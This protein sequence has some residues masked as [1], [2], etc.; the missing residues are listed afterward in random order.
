MMAHALNDRINVPRSALAG[1]QKR[2]DRD[3]LKHSEGIT[4][5]LPSNRVLQE[6][7]ARIEPPN[8]SKKMHLGAGAWILNLLGRA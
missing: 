8:S 4:I 6:P 3:L 7:M 5:Y 2:F 1:L